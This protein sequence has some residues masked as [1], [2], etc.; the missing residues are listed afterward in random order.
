MLLL[1]NPNSGNPTAALRFVRSVTEN[2]AAEVRADLMP[3]EGQAVMAPGVNLEHFEI[4]IAHAEGMIG[5][6]EGA[7]RREWESRFEQL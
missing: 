7:E 5:S 4:N 1:A 3:A 6:T 2:L